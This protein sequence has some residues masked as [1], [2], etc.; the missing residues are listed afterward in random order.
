MRIAYTG[1]NLLDVTEDPEIG[2]RVLVSA[3]LHG[4]RLED[5]DEDDSLFV[6]WL[7]TNLDEEKVRGSG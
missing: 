1:E 6:G 2:R 7:F 3:V 5:L 4:F